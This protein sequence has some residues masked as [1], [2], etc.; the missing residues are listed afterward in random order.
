MFA[1]NKAHSITQVVMNLPNEA[2]EF[3]GCLFLCDYS[4][5]IY[6]ILFYM[7]IQHIFSSKKKNSWL[8]G[9]ISGCFASSPA[10]AFRGIYK[11]IPKNGEFTFPTIHVY[12][13]SKAEDPEFDFHEVGC[14]YI[15]C[16][17]LWC[18]GWD[19]SQITQNLTARLVLCKYCR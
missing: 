13:F 10:D 3:L 12:G 18:L 11:D 7:P 16:I 15:V 4:F 1:S 19:S 17:F 9:L 14:L 6:K 2:A 8:L 5:F